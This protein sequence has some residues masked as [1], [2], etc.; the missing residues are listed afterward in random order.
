MKVQKGCLWVEEAKDSAT[1]EGARNVSFGQEMSH[2]VLED[3]ELFPRR[4]TTNLQE[5]QLKIMGAAR[6]Q[7]GPRGRPLEEETEGIGLGGKGSGLHPGGT[8][9]ASGRGPAPVR[10]TVQTARGTGQH[11]P[12]EGTL[13]CHRQGGVDAGG[14]QP[15]ELPLQKEVRGPAVLGA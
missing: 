6:A 9:E 12:K 8:G 4:K 13:A 3:A 14:L 10:K 15:V 5:S 2:G 1:T 11:P 7:E